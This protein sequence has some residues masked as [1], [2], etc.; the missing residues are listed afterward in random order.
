MQVPNANPEEPSSTRYLPPQTDHQT[1]QS[2]AY[3]HYP[4]DLTPQYTSRHPERD[5]RLAKALGWFSIGIGIAGLLAP[6]RMSQT[7]GVDSHPM[8]MRAIGVREITSGVGILSERKPTGWLWSR[9]A[10][11]AMDLALLGVAV[12]SASA[13]PQRTR[14]T[15]A[16]AAVAGVAALDVLSSVRQMRQNGTQNAGAPGADVYVEK[17]ITVNCSPEDCYRFW[18][19]FENFP[20]FMH[21]IESVEVKSNTRSH[22]RA[23]S[24]IGTT[25]EWEAEVTTDQPG[26]ILAW[27]SLDGSD[28]D[29]AGVVRFERAP[30]DRGTIMRVQMQYSPPHSKA[31]VAITKLLSDAPA[32][33]I[34][35]DLRRF[36]QFIET[37]EIPTTVGQPAGRRSV[38]GRLLRKGEPG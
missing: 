7:A 19:D 4:A 15:L 13:G 16:T 21:H 2:S 6:R 17:S 37:G 23:K 18:R 30:G 32:K 38:V 1:G 22:W 8:L 10:G 9:V 34:D 29:T 12:R 5:Q 24:P 31:G 27:R 3:H 35:E 28:V 36:K 14:V 20:R 26:K 33:Q 11:D 25:V